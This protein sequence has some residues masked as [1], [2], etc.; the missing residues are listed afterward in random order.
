MHACEYGIRSVAPWRRGAVAAGH[1]TQPRTTRVRPRYDDAASDHAYDAGV[2]GLLTQWSRIVS[3][4]RRRPQAIDTTIAVV[5]WL[6]LGMLWNLSTPDPIRGPGTLL[7]LA[8]SGLHLLPLAVR[9]SHPTTAFTLVSLGCL[10]QLLTADA[11][12]PSDLG[13]LAA[14]H[15]LAGYG[16]HVALRRAGLVVALLSGLLGGAD[17]YTPYDTPADSLATGITLSGMAIVAWLWGDVTRRRREVVQ[18]LH[19][20]NEALRR[21]RDQRARIAAQDERTR[22]AREMHDIVAHSLSVVVVQADGAAYVAGHAP[23][24]ERAQ[25]VAA[26]GTIARTA[27]EALAETPALSLIHI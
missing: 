14:A 24:W 4:P 18:R 17:W 21:D 3:W 2:A 23:G 13:F 19:E 6:L 1:A 9:R 20:Q 7:G 15:A 26:L 12:M 27:R 16:R 11:P 5:A 22:I 10:A 25:A 8:L